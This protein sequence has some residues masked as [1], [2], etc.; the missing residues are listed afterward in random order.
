MGLFNSSTSRPLLARRAACWGSL[1]KQR[2]PRSHMQ[3]LWLQWNTKGERDPALSRRADIGFQ[4]PYSYTPRHCSAVWQWQKEWGKRERRKRLKCSRLACV[5]FHPA[6]LSVRV[7]VLLQLEEGAASQAQLGCLSSPREPQRRLSDLPTLGR[8]GGPSED[9]IIQK[10]V[11]GRMLKSGYCSWKLLFLLTI[12]HNRWYSD[13]K[14]QHWQPHGQSQT[15]QLL[16][17]N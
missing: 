16:Q 5:Y 6:R 17:K 14:L 11:W 7:S 15:H 4:I 10:R 13:V 3:N 8:G 2:S 1:G 12:G 9:T